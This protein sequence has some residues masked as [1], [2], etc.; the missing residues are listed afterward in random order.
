MKATKFSWL[1]RDEQLKQVIRYYD[2][3]HRFE[4]MFYRSNLFGH[5]R[6]V[7]AIHKVL[8]PTL[9]L[10]YENYDEDLALAISLVHDDP[11]IDSGDRSL[12]LKLQMGEDAKRAALLEEIEHIK[13][14]ARNYPKKIGKYN[15][16]DLLEHAA[17]KNI[18]EAQS[19]SFADKHDGKHEAIHEVLAGNVV[20][21][22]PII[23]YYQETFAKRNEK[24]PLMKEIFSSDIIKGLPFFEFPVINLMSLFKN[25]KIGPR[26][27]NEETISIKTGIPSYEAWK[28]V[29]LSLPG[30]LEMLTKQVEFHTK[31]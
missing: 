17:F 26:P 12:Q 4:I 16:I 2:Q 10:F 3:D 14:F 6:R 8:I 30:G 25:G 5:T 28:A 20:F 9:K 11:E 19:H 31:F 22:E 23:N 24:F 15:Y 13:K 7:V 18:R 29:T 1:D 21:L 27:H